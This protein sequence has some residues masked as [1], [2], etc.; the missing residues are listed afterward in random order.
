MSAEYVE[1][2]I[3]VHNAHATVGT[4]ADSAKV[5]DTVRLRVPPS[6]ASADSISTS[7][8]PESSLWPRGSVR[9]TGWL[10]WSRR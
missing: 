3:A 7:T 4:C 10:P 8:A 2:L 6:P 5:V 9:E 1:E